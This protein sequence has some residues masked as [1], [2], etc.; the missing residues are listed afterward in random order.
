MKVNLQF[1]NEED[2]LKCSGLFNGMYEVEVDIDEIKQ[3]VKLRRNYLHSKNN[4][5]YDILLEFI[6]FD[7]SY[8]Y[9]IFHPIPR[10]RVNDIKE[11]P[12][13]SLDFEDL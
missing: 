2:V 3:Y 6:G 4:Q 5:Q 7:K 13:S 1:L 10:Y 8:K 9:D 12:K 11:T